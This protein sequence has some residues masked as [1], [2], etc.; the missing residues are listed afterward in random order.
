MAALFLEHCLCVATGDGGAGSHFGP[1]RQKLHSDLDAGRG[2]H[3]APTGGAATKVEAESYHVMSGVPTRPTT[4]AGG[5]LN[6]G[7][8][9]PGD[10]MA[11]TITAPTAGT[12]RCSF[13][14]PAS[15]AA[16]SFG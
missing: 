9:D 8:L 7:W 12:T 11:H 10:W 6:V 1:P 13:G 2:H 14:W 4:D 3:A 5:G 15:T 16:V